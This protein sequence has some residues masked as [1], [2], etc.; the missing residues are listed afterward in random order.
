MRE[1]TF[2]EGMFAIINIRQHVR[3]DRQAKKT[4]ET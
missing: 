1:S 4:S 2:L 3:E